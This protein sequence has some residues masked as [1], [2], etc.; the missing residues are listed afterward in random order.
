LLDQAARELLNQ[1]IGPE[2]TANPQ[3][4][5]ATL[6]AADKGDLAPLQ[7]RIIASLQ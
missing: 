6:L 2:F 5:Y 7:A 3:D 4:Y 1:G